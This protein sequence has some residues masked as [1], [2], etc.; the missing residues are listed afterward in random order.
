MEFPAFRRRPGGASVYG[1]EGPERMV[2]YQRIGSRW[3]RQ[4]LVATAFPE[5]LLIADL[6]SGADGAE[7]MPPE[8]W[9]RVVAEAGD[10]AEPEGGVEWKEDADLAPLTTFG[11]PARARRLFAVHSVAQVRAVLA[12]RAAL[13][14]PPSLLVLGGGSNMLFH[15]DWEGWV[16]RLELM[17][18]RI[19][20]QP[21]GGA[22]GIAGAG[23]RWHDWVD[24]TLGEGWAGLENLSWIPGSVG[25]APIQNIGAY[26]VEL[27]DGFAW[28]EAVRISDGALKRFSPAECGFGY[29]ESVFKGPQKDQWIIVR[30]AF[31]LRRAAEVPVE[32]LRV[33]YGALE[34]ELAGLPRQDWTPRAVSEAV[35]RIRKSKLPDP[36]VWGNAGSFFKNPVIDAA[37]FADLQARFPQI[38]HHLQADGQVKLAAGWLIE[39]AGW[40]GHDRITHGVHDRQ[41]LVLVNKGGATGPQIWELAQDIRKDVLSQFG[42]VLEPEVNQIGATPGS[43]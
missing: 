2:E 16:M 5:K 35:I 25:A 43:R 1:I 41:A 6:L 9:D 4:D 37:S 39:Q 24:W 40:K 38:A 14:P 42:V 19:E 31:H 18:R 17:G 32:E 8:D 15:A 30:V 22:L 20:P 3:L 13:D 7:P 12:R 34:Q 27:K 33:E 21:G 36:A 23:E 26:G 11:V 28:L 29:R 10:S